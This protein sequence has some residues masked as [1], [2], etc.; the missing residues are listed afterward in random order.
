MQLKLIKDAVIESD[1][2][3]R[4]DVSLVRNGKM[5]NVRP[6]LRYPGSKYN[7]SKFIKP[8]WENVNFYEYREPFLGSGAV[9][10]RMPKVELSWLN[11]IDE[12]LIN[13]FNVIADKKLRSKL[14]KK[15]K[16]IEEPNKDLFERFKKWKPKNSVDK[17]YR[18]FV[19]NRTAYSG[20]MNLPNWGFHPRK[21]VQPDKWAARIIQA[22][23]KLENNVKISKISYLDV[24][25][26]PSKEKVWLFVD[27][28][29]FNADQKRAYLHSFNYKDHIQLLEALRK[30]KHFF[31]LTYDNCEQI[32][33]IYSW[34][35]IYEIEWR[36]HTANSN[37]TTRKMGREI[38][39]SNYEID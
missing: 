37:V 35:N 28:P 5:D 18:Y 31:C 9:F 11:D 39:I 25:E 27:P 1:N 29:Y 14:L 2:V 36:Y 22:G 21:S 20:I 3:R 7:A 17:A 13:S 34:A 12:D 10:F 8:F 19:I 33:E 23:A 6:F 24:I 32:K 26:A 15:I 16:G 30:T 4:L 38:I